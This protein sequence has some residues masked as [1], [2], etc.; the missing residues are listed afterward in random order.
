MLCDGIP[1]YVGNG[2]AWTSE[3]QAI[4]SHAWPGFTPS[5]SHH[6]LCHCTDDVTQ[7]A[8]GSNP[9]NNTDSNSIFECK[10]L[11]K[12]EHR[13]E[14][15]SAFRATGVHGWWQNP[16][17]KMEHRTELPLSDPNCELLAFAVVAS[18]FVFVFV[19]VLV[20]LLSLSGCNV[21]KGFAVRLDFSRSAPA[22]FGRD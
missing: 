8:C 4:G 12:M 6:E 19:F 21:S 16:W 1:I 13:T 14:L 10:C 9:T 20:M 18:V 7:Q 3:R 2:L 17:C 22:V 5:N 15:P 11:F